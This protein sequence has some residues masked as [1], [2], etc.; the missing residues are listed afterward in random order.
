[1]ENQLNAIVTQII[2]VS[3]AMKIFRIAPDGWELPDFIPGQFAALALPASAPR[4]VDATPDTENTDPDKLIKR[5][6]SVASSSKSKEFIEFYI[7][8]VR[9]GALTPRLFN[10]KIGDRIELGK[11]MTGMFTL[12]EVPANNNIVLVATG[13]G[14]APYI[15]MLRSNILAGGTRKIAVIHGAANSWDLGY[16]SELRLLE[17]LSDRFIYLPTIIDVDKEHAKW[18]G[19]TRFVQDMWAGGVVEKVWGLKPTPENTHL[20][21]CGNPKMVESMFEI[22]GKE[23]F[24]EHKRKEPGQVHV[25]SWG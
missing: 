6:Y 13:T 9:S 12:E 3:P 16:S 14:V 11:K 4:V 23:G 22:L 21:L 10:L 25:E 2:Q 17:S 8:L 24:K 18:N 1:M 7:S 5:V 15:S 20:F 19:D